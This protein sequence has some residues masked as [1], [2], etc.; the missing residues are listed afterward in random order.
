LPDYG[1]V[2]YVQPCPY[3]D[4]FLLDLYKDESL[5]KGGIRFRFLFSFNVNVGSGGKLPWNW[6]EVEIEPT[7]NSSVILP[8]CSTP[9]QAVSF[10]TPQKIILSATSTEGQ[11]E[12]HRH[13]HRKRKSVFVRFWNVAHQDYCD[14][15]RLGGTP[16]LTLASAILRVPWKYLGY[17]FTRQL[18]HPC[19]Q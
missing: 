3:R 19:Y 4:N 16:A 10:K 11:S 5:E 6:R 7:P 13:D 1:C 18:G 2:D 12:T 9:P 17:P 8:L 14:G 15:K